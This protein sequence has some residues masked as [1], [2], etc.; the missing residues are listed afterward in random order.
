MGLKIRK[1]RKFTEL[2]QITYARGESQSK[3]S[4]IVSRNESKPDKYDT[5]EM[6]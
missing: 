1:A 3:E 4:I 6:I 5:L 2:A